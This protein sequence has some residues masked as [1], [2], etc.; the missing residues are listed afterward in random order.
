MNIFILI[1]CITST[2]LY[3]NDKND[4]YLG[5]NLSSSQGQWKEGPE[6]F[7][8]EELAARFI[9]IAA[10]GLI[11]KSL[12]DLRLHGEYALAKSSYS[13]LYGEFLTEK[14]LFTPEFRFRLG[15]DLIN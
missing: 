11:K 3:A 5:L 6:Q 12:L 1:F 10:E 9:S 15:F 7:S 13:Y 2:A 14:S 4:H 8:T